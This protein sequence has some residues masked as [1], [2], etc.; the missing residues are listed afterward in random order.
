MNQSSSKETYHHGD[1]YKA[2]LDGATTML[3]Q[4]GVEA[5]SLRKIAQTVG[6]SRTAAYH[7]FEDKH[8]LLCAIA[9]NGFKQWRTIAD[10]ILNGTFDST[11][12]QYRAFVF[13]YLDFAISNPHLYNLMFGHTIWQTKRANEQLKTAAYPTFNQQVDMVEYWQTQNL[14]SNEHS[15]LRM[16]QVVWGTLHGI[17]KLTIDGIYID[18]SSITQMCECAIDMMIKQHST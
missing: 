14:L 6:V 11:A 17:A 3:A 13:S 10:D 2:L 9:T 7:H 5:L 1:L 4:E 8:A 16:S 15:A 18:Q 12:E